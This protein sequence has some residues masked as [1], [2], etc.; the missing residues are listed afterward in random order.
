[1]QGNYPWDQEL[2]PGTQ[3]LLQEILVSPYRLYGVRSVE[4]RCPVQQQLGTRD[5]IQVLSDH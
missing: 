1:M 2:D 5:G 4:G 3:G